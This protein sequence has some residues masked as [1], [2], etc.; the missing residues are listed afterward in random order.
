VVSTTL[1]AI[2]RSSRTGGSCGAALIGIPTG[3]PSERIVLDIDI[4]DERAN[5]FDRLDDLG[6]VLPATLMAHTAS[7][8]LHVYFEPAASASMPCFSRTALA[9][10]A[11]ASS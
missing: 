6:I 5:G 10:T 3:R 8:R 2:R 9:A 1:L 4:K 11:R 7:G